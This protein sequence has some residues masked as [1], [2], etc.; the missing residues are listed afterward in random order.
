M[1]IIGLKV[2]VN[3]YE[4]CYVCPR[5]CVHVHMCAS[6][7]LYACVCICMCMCVHS[8]VH[9]RRTPGAYPQ[10]LPILFFKTEFPT[11]TK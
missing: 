4:M 11:F 3:S 2:N 1:Y 5:T 6:V 10:A 8:V 7:C 9:V